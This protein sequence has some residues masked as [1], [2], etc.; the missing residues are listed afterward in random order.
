MI[1]RQACLDPGRCVY[2]RRNRASSEL[3]RAALAAQ[4]DLSTKYVREQEWYRA[5]KTVE[6]LIP[7]SIAVGA[8]EGC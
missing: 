3:A 2:A 1:R 8:P 4:P 5:R 7:T 6:K